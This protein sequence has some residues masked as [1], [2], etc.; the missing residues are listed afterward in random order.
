MHNYRTSNMTVSISSRFEAFDRLTQDN[1]G[2]VQ[3]LLSTT[4]ADDFQPERDLPYTFKK[5]KYAEHC[6][7][8]VSLEDQS[9]IRNFEPL[10][11]GLLE[12]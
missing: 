12:L 3:K 4:Y 2:K 6:S 8:Q 11:L 7:A 1:I 9:L 5:D 10:W